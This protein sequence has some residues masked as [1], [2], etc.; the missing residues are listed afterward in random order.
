MKSIT[1]KAVESIDIK[2]D[3]Y[4]YIVDGIKMLSKNGYEIGEYNPHGTS[5]WL[6]QNEHTTCV[7]IGDCE[8]DAIDNAVDDGAWDSLEMSYTDHQE[9]ES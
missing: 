5:A 3:N 6:I 9:Y 2:D 1:R 8:Q 7:A 4:Q